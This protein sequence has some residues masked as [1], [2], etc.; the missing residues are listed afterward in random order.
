MMIA[1]WGFRIEYTA[2][3]VRLTFFPQAIL[4]GE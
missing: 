4:A 3:T 2:I 1:E